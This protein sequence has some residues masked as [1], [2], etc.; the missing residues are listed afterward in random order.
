M[1]QLSTVVVLTSALLAWTQLSAAYPVY[2]YDSMTQTG[3][4]IEAA[5]KCDAHPANVVLPD[6][7]PHGKPQADR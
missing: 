7:S 5:K 3:E 6:I 1:L 2:W 4:V